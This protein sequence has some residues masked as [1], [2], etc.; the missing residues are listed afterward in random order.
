[1]TLAIAVQYPYGRLREA[2]ESLSKIRP[3][4]RREAIIFLTDSRW[5]YPDHYE[6]D[7]IKLHDIDVSTVVAY[8]GKVNI[9]EHC[10]D[11]LR[12]KVNSRSSKRIDVIDTF[13]RTFGFHKR[14]NDKNNVETGKLSFLMGKYLKTGEAKLI[15]L[16]SSDFK[17]KFITGI[18]G[19]GDRGAYEEVRKVVVLKLNDIA[20]FDGTEKDY[21]TIAVIVAGAMRMLAIGN[22]SFQTVGGP[23]Q[24]WVLD[25]KG[26]TESQLH[27]TEDPTGAKDEWHRATA[28]RSELKTLKDKY[29]LGPDYLLR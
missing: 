12:R 22:S 26:I 15:L 1:M 28:K 4:Q 20:N 2:L 17:P 8:S 24:Y 11:N 18:E 10:V 6:D 3:L 9:A 13:R 25:R 16:E 19:I 27:Y 21:F 7:G 5:T 14:Y 23:I 29:N